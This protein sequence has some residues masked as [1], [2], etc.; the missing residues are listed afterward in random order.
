LTLGLANGDTINVNFEPT[1]S[2]P[3]PAAAWG[4]LAMIGGL[5]LFQFRKKVVKA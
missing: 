2:T 1:P 5:G 3:L 4:G